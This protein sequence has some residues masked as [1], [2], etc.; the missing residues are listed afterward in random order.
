MKKAS[1][2][3]HFPSKEAI[4]LETLEYSYAKYEVFLNEVWKLEDLSEM[5]KRLINFAY[6]EKNLYGV[7]LQRGYCRIDA[8]RG[9]ISEKIA[10]NQ[11]MFEERFS[12]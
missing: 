3:H 5:L 10:L 1:L 2:Y 9:F 12:R 4:F 6:S 8:V 7:V 11:R